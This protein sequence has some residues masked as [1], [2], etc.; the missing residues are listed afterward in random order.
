[1]SLRGWFEI[2]GVWV[3]LDYLLMVFFL[4]CLL[5]RGMALLMNVLYLWGRRIVQPC[6]VD[7][8]R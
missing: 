6:D 7:E 2:V 5:I 4:T 3:G 1:M 8:V